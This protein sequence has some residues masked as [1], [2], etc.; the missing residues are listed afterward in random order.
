MSVFRRRPEEAPKPD[1]NLIARLEVELGI[2]D[3]PIVAK[4]YMTR[5]EYDAGMSYTPPGW[6]AACEA[7]R[8]GIPV[9]FEDYE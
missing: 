4:G 8:A 1:Y 6:E 2:V 9:R 5:E 7:L 3:P